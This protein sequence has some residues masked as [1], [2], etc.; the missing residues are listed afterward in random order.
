MAELPR[1]TRINLYFVASDGLWRRATQAAIIEW[2]ME[3][4]P[5]EFFVKSVDY[6]KKGKLIFEIEIKESSEKLWTEKKIANLILSYNPKGFTLA[7]INATTEFIQEEVIAGV[8]AAGSTSLQIAA[9]LVI[10][11]LVYKYA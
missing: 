7:F 4:H 1:G 6:Q 8:K 11:Y 10:V 5:E 3:A 2:R 9:V